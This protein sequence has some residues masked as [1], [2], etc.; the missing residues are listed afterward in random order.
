LT[1]ENL[2]FE[3]DTARKILQYFNRNPKAADTVEGIARW[4]LLDESIRSNLETVM[5]TIAW[6]VSQGLLVKESG[7]GAETVFRVN[8]ERIEEVK[9]FVEAP[10]VS[11]RKRKKA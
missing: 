8:P 10:K 11:E 1:R 6:L 7:S 9:H 4:R 5:G 2:K 3:L